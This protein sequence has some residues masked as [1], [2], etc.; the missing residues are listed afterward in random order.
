MVYR[1]FF[2][3]FLQFHDLQWLAYLHNLAHVLHIF[4]FRLRWFARARGLAD[5]HWPRELREL[6]EL[7]ESNWESRMFLMFLAAEK[8]RIDESTSLWKTWL[9]ERQGPGRDLHLLNSF[10]FAGRRLQ[11]SVE[12][13]SRTDENFCSERNYA[14]QQLQHTTTI[15]KCIQ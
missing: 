5:L 8:N 1:W 13:K 4:R 6:R 7:R 14:I 10:G 15:Q 3:V 11:W 2:I 12:L 9:R